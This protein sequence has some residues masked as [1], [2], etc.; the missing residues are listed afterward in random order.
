MATEPL[1]R[2]EA[3]GMWNAAN[4]LARVG[5]SGAV[6]LIRGYQA[7]IRPHL[8]GQCKYCPT[9]S[10]YGIEA[11]RT[12]GLLRGGWLTLRRLLRCHPFAQGGIDP[13]PPNKF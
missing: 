8:I 12:H 11:I 5:R 6:L 4:G 9:C 13:V 10:E 3:A 7:C 1:L 2:R